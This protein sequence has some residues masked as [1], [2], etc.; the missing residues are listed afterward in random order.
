MEHR[1]V[2]VKAQEN[3]LGGN[4]I[5]FIIDINYIGFVAIEKD[6]VGISKL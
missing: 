3:A 2:G 4:R 5:N 6:Y 1:R